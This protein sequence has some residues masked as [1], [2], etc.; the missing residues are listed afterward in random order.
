MILKRYETI[1]AQSRTRILKKIE[2]ITSD[3][4]MSCIA[5]MDAYAADTL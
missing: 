4:T 3:H 5:M 1:Q 2:T